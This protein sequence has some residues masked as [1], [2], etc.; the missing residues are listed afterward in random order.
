M[1]R[2]FVFLKKVYNYASNF[3]YFHITMTKKEY[4][5]KLLSKLS[6]QWAYADG[7]KIVVEQTNVDDSVV[8]GLYDVLAQAV[9]ETVDEIKKTSLMKWL[10]A[11][12]HIQEFQQDDDELEKELDTILAQI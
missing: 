8:D 11:L 6:G 3:N 10:H 1:V 9:S 12:Q 5:I 7:L 4:L 2:F